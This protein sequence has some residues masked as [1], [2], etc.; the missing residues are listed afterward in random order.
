MGTHTY[1][2]DAT[3][4]KINRRLKKDAG[5]TTLSHGLLI[6]GARYPCHTS[7]PPQRTGASGASASSPSR[8][9][10][11]VVGDKLGRCVRTEAALKEA[12]R[13]FFCPPGA[14][15]RLPQ[16]LGA[17]A[18]IRAWFEHQTEYGFYASSL[19][20][21]F[22]AD[23]D[24]APLRCQ[25]C[26]EAYGGRATCARAHASR[27]TRPPW[28][29]SLCALSALPR[30][31]LGGPAHGGA[32][33][34]ARCRAQMIDFAHVHPLD[35]RCLH[36]PRRGRRLQEGARDEGYLMGL[37]SLERLLRSLKDHAP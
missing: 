30:D 36:G 27:H 13:G 18:Q 25:V 16:A 31:S 5:S 14:G 32:R 34:G 23:D 6:V 12:L 24:S 29:A 35:E 28:H 19:L 7:E 26:L 15:R 1:A 37:R 21:C 4:D 17:V 20:F 11:R 33:G 22:D 9:P 2:P 3:L 8:A 10:M